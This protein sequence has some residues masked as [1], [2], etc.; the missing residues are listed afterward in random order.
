MRIEKI[1]IENFRCFYSKFTLTLNKGVNVLVGDNEAGKSTILEAVNLGLSGILNGK[2][3]R[4]QLSSY[5]F[6]HRIIDEYIES[7]KTDEK[8]S[9]PY[10]LIE[11]FFADD[12][13]LFEGNGNSERKKACGISFKIEFDP[14]YESEYQALVSGGDVFSLPVEYYR[15]VWKSFARES[16]TGRSVPLKS[17]LIDST[18]NRYQN[19][20]DV[21]ISRIIRDDLDDTE[22]V[23]LSQAHRRMKEAFGNDVAVEAINKKIN[24]KAK[25]SNKKLHVSVDM[26]SHNSWETSLMA[27]LDKTPFQQ[28]GKGEQC[29][30]K[31]NLALSHQKAQEANIILLEEPENHL[32][33][34]KL[35][36]LMGS[37][38]TSCAEKQALISTH[39]SFVANKLGLDH[40]ILLK[41]KKVTRLTDLSPDTYNFF[42][43]LP[44]YQTLRLILC[45]KAVLVEGDSDELIFQK[46]Y[47]K[48]NGGKLPIQDG[49]DVISV[50]LTFKRFLEIAEKL[51]HPVAVITDNDKDYTNNITKKYLACK[52]VD[53]VSI[54]ADKRESLNTLEPQFVDANSSDLKGLCKVVG[55]SSEKY[56][57]A[58]DVIVY[59]ESNKTTWALRVFESET[60]VQY[61]DYIERAVRWCVDE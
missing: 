45:K 55:I 10:I 26:S 24:S 32:S 21:Y 16:I 2:Y 39:S 7:L 18:S 42:K 47:M 8:K 25:V 53:S 59:M 5:L 48:V 15:T 1:N 4:N 30:V 50:K 33:H 38:S 56:I 37:I 34:S 35:N 20:S 23:G 12:F 11:I 40:L 43:K 28:I 29:I 9:P 44:G 17:V 36:E 49:I 54:F 3:L 57:T 27:Y 19:G 58:E 46:A 31:A 6:N 14:D 61:P 13:P 52:D 22:K 41:N 51:E 60:P